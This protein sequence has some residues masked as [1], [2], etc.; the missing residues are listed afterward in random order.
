MGKLHTCFSTKAAVAA[1][2]GNNN[3]VKFCGYELLVQVKAR[4]YFYRSCSSNFLVIC[5]LFL[6]LRMV[7]WRSNSSLSLA[8][9]LFIVWGSSWARNDSNLEANLSSSRSHSSLNSA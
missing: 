2:Q 9:S 6:S 5:S 3:G 7:M 8:L 1:L 4:N